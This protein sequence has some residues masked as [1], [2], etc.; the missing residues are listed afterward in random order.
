VVES[1]VAIV[2]GPVF[3]HEVVGISGGNKYF[4][5][6]VASQEFIDMTHW[7]GALIT[8]Y[9]IIGTT[10]I[11]PVRAMINEGASLIP[12]LRLA[13]CLVVESGS[14]EIEAAAFGTAERA[15]ELAAEVAA[16]THVTYVDEPFRKVIS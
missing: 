16:Q 2:V 3:P 1:D 8:S 4:I 12:T 15:W 5:P 10:G 9:E 13:L 7:V 11:T 6:G 14:G